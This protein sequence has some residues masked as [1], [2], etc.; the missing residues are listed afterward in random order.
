MKASRL[1]L[2]LA[3][4]WVALLWPTLTVWHDAI[5]WIG[6]IS[7]YS[8]VCTHWGA[9]EGAKAKEMVEAER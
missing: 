3:G 8:N 6:F 2:L 4:V 1:H 7:I 5:W 9:Y